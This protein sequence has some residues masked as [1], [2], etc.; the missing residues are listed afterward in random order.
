LRRWL[1]S[2]WEAS[3]CS[4]G[5]SRVRPSRGSDVGD[6]RRQLG[7]AIENGLFEPNLSPDLRTEP[8]EITTSDLLLP[9]QEVTSTTSSRSRFRVRPS[10]RALQAR[11]LQLR[12]LD[13][14][15]RQ[16]PGLAGPPATSGPTAAG[17][18]ADQAPQDS[19]P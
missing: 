1:R 7:N 4:R 2:C 19:M 5:E 3:D 14:Y 13:N 6:G 15:S 8:T 17:L 12:Q 18:A 9:Q 11:S 10:T 16:R